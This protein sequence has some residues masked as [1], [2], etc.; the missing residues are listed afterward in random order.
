MGTAGIKHPLSLFPFVSLCSDML[1]TRFTVFLLGASVMA[2]TAPARAQDT[3]APPPS[4]PQTGDEDEDMIVVTG[5]RPRGS[6]MGDIEP[7]VTFSA[8]DIRSFG[9]SSLNDLIAELAAQ[10]ASGQGRGDERP[11][12]L[13]GGKRVSS[14]AEIRDIPTEAIQRVEILPEEVAL[15]YGYRPNQKVV[16]IVLRRRFK[17]FTGEL[18]AGA[19][20]EGG[21]FSPEIEGSYLRIGDFGRLNL[22][23]EYERSAALYEDQRA[24][25]A[26]T[27][28]QP[29]ARLGNITSTVSGAEIDPALSTA[30]GRPATVIGVP[31]S[32]A[33]AIPTLADFASGAVNMTD[34]RPYRTLMPETDTLT[35]NAVLAR[36]IFT[37]VSASFNGSLTYEESDSARGLA[38]TTLTLPAASPYSPFANPVALH[39]T[40][41]EFGALEQRGRD[42]TGHFGTTLSGSAGSW[43]WTFTGNYDHAVS[44]TTTDRGYDLTAFQ[45]G[46]DALD[47]LFNPYAPL[48]WSSIS[49]IRTDYARSISRVA[50]ADLV[51]S[52]TLFTLPAGAV[53]TTLSVGGAMRSLDSRSRLSGVTT[54]A[55]LSRDAVTGQFSLDVPIASRKKGFLEPLGELSANFNIAYNRLSDFGGLRTLGAGLNWTPVKPLSLIL[56]YSE[57]EGAPSM[58]Q[59]GSPTVTTTGVRVFDYIRGETVDISRISGGN[60]DL[61]ADNRR[62]FKLGMTLRPLAGA[63]LTLVANYANSRVRDPIAAFPTATAAIEAAFPDRFL[64]DA[65]GRLLQIDGRPINFARQ[66]QEELRWGLNFSKQLS[67]PPRPTGGSDR[68]REGGSGGGGGEQP[69]LRDLLPSGQTTRQGENR[70][71]SGGERSGGERS[72]PGGPSAGP[73]GGG[74]GRPGGGFGRGPG[75]RGTRLQMAVYHTVHLRERIT[76]FGGG[77]SLDLLNGDAIGSSGGQPRHEVEIQT[78]LTHNG[79]GARISADWQSATTVNGG[80]DG[81]QAL[82]FSSLATVNLRLFASLGQQQALV[83]KWPFLRGTRVRLS[84]DNLFNQRQ[85]VRDGN[86]DTPISYQPAYLDPLGRS[87]RLSFRKLF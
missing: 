35:F 70:A 30:M 42:L 52:G 32:A 73:G 59:L 71:A 9:V 18:E 11:V 5:Q 65:D 14:F 83:S 69:S 38:D 79:L 68:R 41:D 50:D 49:G 48:G 66:D 19:A 47:P 85:H 27:A 20:T 53:S 58:Q 72:G 39:R 12:V 43:L 8:A 74:F 36:T 22:A 13:L 24:I 77:P 61:A 44:R 45:N 40:L 62:L 63:D 16:N 51:A 33:T 82:R 81:G 23:L 4:A 1:M 76:I 54:I 29:Y 55:D 60:P 87:V 80:I 64:R 31:S 56:S 86:G 10:T 7:E 57:D 17:A 67:T 78:G 46:I 3:P 2:L 75:G 26:Q 84:I 21:R 6:V 28:S 25:I 37:N 34:S 15:K